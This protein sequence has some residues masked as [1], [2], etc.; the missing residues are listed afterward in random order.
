M[1]I[2]PFTIAQES[3]TWGMQYVLRDASGNYHGVVSLV[4]DAKQRRQQRR[5]L[6]RKMNSG[7][8]P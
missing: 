4:G 7:G 8:K 6:L 1:G 2:R 5:E 3:R